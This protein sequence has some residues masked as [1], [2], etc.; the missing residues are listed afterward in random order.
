MNM[1]MTFEQLLQ[2]LGWRD[3]EVQALNQAIKD[4]DSHIEQLEQKI[5][6]LQKMYDNLI[7]EKTGE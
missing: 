3:M 2:R 1:N 5:D 6:E 7:K 4:K